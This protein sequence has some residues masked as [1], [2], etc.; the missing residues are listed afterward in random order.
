MKIVI[1]LSALALLTACAG[2]NYRPLV[3]TAGKDP[4]RYEHDLRECQGYAQ[5]VSGAGEGAAIGVAAG[6]IIGA[7]FGG[8]AGGG[9]T[10]RNRASALGAASGGISGAAGGETDQRNVIRR[11]M[12]GRGYN[13][14]Q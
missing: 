9:H 8:L 14:L 3:D 12:A 5:Q 2:A 1:A 13:V 11:C 7:L 10:Y 6:A 4:G